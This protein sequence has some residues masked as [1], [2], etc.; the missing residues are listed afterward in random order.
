MQPE[1]FHPS[2]SGNEALFPCDV[3][4]VF[5]K[6]KKTARKFLTTIGFPDASMIES[7]DVAMVQPRLT[8]AYWADKDNN[9]FNLKFVHGW[10]RDSFAHDMRIFVFTN[11]QH[12]RFV[13][14]FPDF[15]SISS[16]EEESITF[17]K[18]QS[19]PLGTFLFV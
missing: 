7:S 4:L 8:Y 6:D 11:M 15:F 9:L 12:D 10:K 2:I 19:L 14:N 5:V 1:E 16:V 18:H 17:E 13:T 3:H